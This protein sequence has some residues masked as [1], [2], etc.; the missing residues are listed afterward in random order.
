MSDNKEYN[1]S[2]EFENIT[3]L[4]LEEFIE[5]VRTVTND[6]AEISNIAAVVVTKTISNP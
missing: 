1:V 4:T 5:K 6:G 3:A 2:F